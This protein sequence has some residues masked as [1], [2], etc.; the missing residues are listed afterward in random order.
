[1]PAGPSFVNLYPRR[2]GARE[3][4][5]VETRSFAARRTVGGGSLRCTGETCAFQPGDRPCGVEAEV[6]RRPLCGSPGS[7]LPAAGPAGLSVG[8]LV[9]DRRPSRSRSGSVGGRAG[10]S[11]AWV[12]QA[13][14]CPIPG[15]SSPSGQEPLTH[16]PG[17]P[18]RTSGPRAHEGPAKEGRDFQSLRISGERGLRVGK[19]VAAALGDPARGSRLSEK[20]L[21]CK[22]AGTHL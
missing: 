12:G 15:R 19:R 11:R 14:P 20:R 2:W 5:V 6:R 7:V 4:A 16:P 10:A 18:A 1:M 22:S 3:S 13:G 9:I 8:P 21:S 17:S